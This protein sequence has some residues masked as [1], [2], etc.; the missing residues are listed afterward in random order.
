MQPNPI[1]TSLLVFEENLEMIQKALQQNVIRLANSRLA[2]HQPLRPNKEI[3]Y[4]ETREHVLPHSRL[5]ISLA[6]SF[7][8]LD[9]I[10]KPKTTK[11]LVLVDR[12]AALPEGLRLN[13]DNPD[14]WSVAVTR[15]MTT[16]EYMDRVESLIQNWRTLGKFVRYD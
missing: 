13:Q 8:Q 16:A 9:T 12:F 7:K 5:G 15:K 4:D 2:P 11:W 10:F 14:H 1:Q 6:A 3:V